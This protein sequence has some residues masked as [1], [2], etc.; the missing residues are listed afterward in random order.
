MGKILSI[1]HRGAKGYLPENTLE[2]FKKGFE[3]GCDGVEFDVHLSA[4]GEIIVIHD[5]TIDRT[6]NVQGLIKELT[7]A[8][9]KSASIHNAEIPTLSE[10]LNITPKECLVNIELKSGDTV[11]PVTD[12]LKRY[13]A[14]GW[15]YDKFLV[16]SFDWIA[17]KELRE[18]NPEV[19]LGVLTETDLDLAVAYAE[20]LQAES[21]H[22][23]YHLL[24][25]ENVMEIKQ[26]GLKVFAWTINEPA[27]IA[28][29]K[30][31]QVTGI[32]TDFPD[33][34]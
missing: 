29:I 31:Y 18:L 16:S 2:A 9:I 22:A 34:V 5:A 7:L 24:T 10:V 12:L 15:S 28:K 11:A 33:R 21:I 1:A 8:Q 3:L 6:T 30:S 27:D 23:Y 25:A 20:F 4:D 32:I 13:K 14:E 17:L 19:P 26:K